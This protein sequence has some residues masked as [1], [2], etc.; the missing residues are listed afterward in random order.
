MSFETKVLSIASRAL[1]EGE[2]AEF[3][4]GSLFLNCAEKTSRKVFSDLFMEF[5]GQVLISKTPAEYVIDFT[6]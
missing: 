6:A 4:A 1:Q 3:Y 5:K 2:K